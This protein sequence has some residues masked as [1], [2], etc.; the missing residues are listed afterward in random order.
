MPSHSSSKNSKHA[1]RTGG[2]DRRRL[3]IVGIVA[4]VIIAV[5]AVIATSGGGPS[6]TN[7]TGPSVP[8]S[9]QPALAANRCPLTDLPAPG[10]VVPQREPVAVKIGNE[11]GPGPGGTGAARPQS[12]LNEADVVYDTPA[13]GFIMRYIAVFQCQSASSI[14]PVRSV[15]WVD[16]HILNEFNHVALAFVGGVNPN[17]ATVASTPWIDD[18]N[19]FLH[20]GAYTTDPNRTA[21]DATYTSTSAIL[22]LFKSHH[23]P[24]P[25]FHYTPAPAPNATPAASFGINFS[26]GTDVI[27]KWDAATGQ[28]LHTYS[29]VPDIDQL[30]GKQVSTTNIVVQIVHY[31]IG[32]YVESPGGTGDIQSVTVGK[33][34]GY[35]LR[36]G[37]AVKVIWRR[38]NLNSP[39]S[40]SDAATGQ[41]LGLAPGR[42]WV[43]L[44]PDTVAKLPGQFK[45]TP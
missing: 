31:T 36:N 38:A 2:L 11:P 34:P 35:L 39:T 24:V 12:G 1:P 41:G 8:P 25:I 23:A 7:A 19:E 18:A 6:N 16:W 42:T 37:K 28:W 17:Q 27:W 29:G 10:G 15:R 4:I 21:P 32:P 20:Y 44:V 45:I 22:K 33:G 9:T 5:I 13:E 3:A 14:G 26:A 30:T 43:E 40:F